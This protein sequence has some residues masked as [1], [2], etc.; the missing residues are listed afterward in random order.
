MVV[1]GF[2]PQIYYT[3]FCTNYNT[4]YI[5][6]RQKVI[7]RAPAP[8]IIIGKSMEVRGRGEACMVTS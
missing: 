5:T 4:L 1:P 7:T 8:I 2:P 6:S 3:R